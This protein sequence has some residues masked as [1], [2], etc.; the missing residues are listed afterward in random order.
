MLLNKLKQVVGI[1]KTKDHGVEYNPETN[2]FKSHQP[3][4]VRIYE[5]LR[6]DLVEVHV[7]RAPSNGMFSIEQRASFKGA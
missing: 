7:A 6:A 5:Q 1:G 3:R 4:N 2:E